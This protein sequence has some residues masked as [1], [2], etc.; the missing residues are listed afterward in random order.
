MMKLDREPCR[1]MVILALC[2]G[3]RCS[4]LVAETDGPG[5]WFKAV[6]EPNLSLTDPALT[7]SRFVGSILK[8]AQG[9]FP[10]VRAVASKL[11]VSTTQSKDPAQLLTALHLGYKAIWSVPWLSPDPE[12]PVNQMSIDEIVA[13]QDAFPPGVVARQRTSMFIPP[14]SLI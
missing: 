11:R 7:E 4:E 3:V 8:G 14:R 13:A 6:G 10:V 9:N 5:L 1:T 2:T 12:A